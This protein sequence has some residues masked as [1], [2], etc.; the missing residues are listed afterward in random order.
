MNAKIYFKNKRSNQSEDIADIYVES[1]NSLKSI[2]CPKSFNSRTI[3]EFLLV[4]LV[5]AKAN[6]ISY[7]KNIG[8]LKHK[9]CDR[10]KF[11]SK[12]LKMIGIKSKETKDSLKIY[13]NPNLDLKK[14][15]EIKNFDKDHR[16]C[17]LSFVAALTLGGSWK[18]ND[19]DSIK[20]SFPKFVK[21]IKKIG[22]KIK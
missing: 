1:S 5:C 8:E 22:A 15:Y 10:L 16:V 12:F 19:V 17:M 20:T 7:F 13:G 11:A 3:D 18:I 9:E 21:I 14:K 6:G 2:N 4:F